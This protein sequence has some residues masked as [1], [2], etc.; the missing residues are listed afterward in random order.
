MAGDFIGPVSVAG[1]F[2]AGRPETYAQCKKIQTYN[3]N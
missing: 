1:Q 2:R 3:V